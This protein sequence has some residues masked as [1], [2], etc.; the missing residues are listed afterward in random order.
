MLI[1]IMA[2]QSN[3]QKNVSPV[4]LTRS[5]REPLCFLSVCSSNMLFEKQSTAHTTMERYCDMI[6]TLTRVY[7][8]MSLQPCMQQIL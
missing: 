2:R 8:Y 7:L 4:C 3:Y 5:Q 1:Q 6:Q